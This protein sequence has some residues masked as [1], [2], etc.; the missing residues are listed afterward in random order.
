[1][2][3]IAL[4]LIIFIT[5]FN[6]YS[7]ADFHDHEILNEKEALEIFN[8]ANFVNEFTKI[9][10]KQGYDFKNDIC[11]KNFYTINHSNLL[12]QIFELYKDEKNKTYYLKLYKEQLKKFEEYLPLFIKHESALRAEYKRRSNSAILAKQGVVNPLPQSACTNMDIE[13]G[14]LSGWSTNFSNVGP[15]FS[16]FWTPAGANSAFA[17]TPGPDAAVP[18]INQVYSGSFSACI[19]VLG[20]GNG[21]DWRELQQ[22][23]LVTNANKDFV[24]Y[25]AVITDG[26]AHAC[27][28]NPFFEVN[29]FDASNNVI[30][31][32]HVSLIGSASGGGACSQFTGWNTAGWYDFL[33]W[34]PVIVP[35]GAYIG[36]NVTVKF[37]VQRCTAYGHGARAYIEASC[38]PVDLTV[39]GNLICPGKTVSLV[40]PNT[41]GY[42][43]NWSGPGGFSAS[44]N[45]VS[46]SLSGAYTVTMSLISNPTCKMVM[47]TIL[48]SVPSP[49]AN[50]NYTVTP[51]A[52]TNS[53]PVISSS[54]PAAGDPISNYIWVWGDASSNG[55]GISTNHTYASVG[56]KTVELKI[57]STAGCRDSIQQSFSFNPG[58]VASFNLANSCLGTVSSFTSTSTSATGIAFQDWN[59]GDGSTNGSGVNPS[60]SYSLTGTY[61]VTLVVTAVGGCTATVTQTVAVYPKP[62]VTFTANPVC[63]NSATSFTNSSTITAPG[64]INAWA[65]D[66]DND[67]TTDNITQSPA[68]TFTPAGTYNIELK[69][70][71]SN[72]CSDS[73]VV[74]IIINANPI[75]TFT[76][77]AAC[78]NAN[79][80]LNNTSTIPLPNTINLY[81]WAFGAGSTPVNSSNQNPPSLTYNTSG[82]KTITLTL[83]ANNSCTAT[84]TNT[85]TINPFPVA[86]FSTTSV[87]Q[88]TATAFTDM[89]TISSGTI[90]TWAWDY[91]NDG[92]SD[93]ATQNPTF[94]YPLSGSY[95]AAL[96]VS[97]TAGCTNTFTAPVTVWGHTIPDFSPNNV[98]FGTATT[99]SNNTNTTTNANVGTTP[100]YSW[101][102]ADGSGVQVLAGSPAH[103]YTLGGNVNATYNVT[104]TATSSHNCI[105]N[106][107]KAVNVYA[108]PTASFTS[109]S[110]CLGSPSHMADATNGNGNTVNN[111]IWDFLSNG[112]IDASGVSNPNFTFPAYGNNAVTYTAS[113]TPVAGLTCQN[114]TSTIT[115]WINPNPIPD[116]T[117]VNKCINAQP[118]TFDA[119]NST[120]AVG[121]NTAYT[122]AF[123][124]GATSP[125]TITPTHTF[126]TAGLYNTTLTVTSNKGCQTSVTKQVE[127]YQKPL[128]SI[129][130]SSACFKSAMTFT[131]GSLA[132]S[133]TVNSWSWDLNNT[134]ASYEGFGEFPNFNFPVAGSQTVHLVA[135][136]THGCTDTFTTQVY[137]DYLP[138]P[139]FTVD[140]PSGCPLHCVTFTDNTPALTA[141]GI[142]N[143]WHW[144]FGDGQT[145]TVNSP[146]VQSHCYDNTSNSQSALYDVKLIVTSDK[147]CKDSLNKQ[148]FITVYPTPIAQYTVD[149]NPGS[150]VTPTEHF[151][152]QSVDY[153]KWWW[154]F[155]DG[156]ISDSTHLNPY[157]TYLSLDASDYYSYLIVA[158]QYGCKDTANVKLEIG[159][160]F[161]FYIPNAFTPD[162]GDGIND[163]F[164]GMGVGIDKFEMWIFDR[165]GVSIF[166]SD[167]IYK[168][169]NGKVQGTEALVQ[170]DVYTWKVKI[171]DVLGKGHNY[172]GHVTVLR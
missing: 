112:T 149:P 58:P 73:L 93:N 88:S 24:F 95:T 103:T 132:G 161:V 39:N 118:N 154:C 11:L 7:Q 166:Y 150:I 101:D 165:W 153:T 114:I 168:G 97:T 71:S 32:S 49:T 139:A 41:P 66:F 6:V 126:V 74:P 171:K 160:E 4:L 98:C 128:M 121:T 159:P 107:V 158:N 94:T 96:T 79:V 33:N 138:T 106:I 82:V 69:A 3:K 10:T 46:P 81:D 122:W 167:D 51:C 157:H 75:A 99:F 116:F 131:A 84:I 155:G 120:I 163:F 61:S 35:L 56:T 60:H 133:G 29:V 14:S 67:G 52:P 136:T 108:I 172:V 117:F 44:T 30:P 109:D 137:V 127:V 124:D 142:N 170:Q 119:S 9:T 123:G 86:N 34:T 63:L 2:K 27:P 22:T 15:S 125:S 130:A 148:A 78:V 144:V 169:W 91:T 25:T 85:V 38:N 16:N 37:R 141:P 13:T 1:M 146:T 48:V 151:I 50:F 76:P 55:S 57:V 104:L 26:G 83:T 113:T 77:I 162:N 105:D 147:G 64:T 87:C 68:N 140:K 152:N 23:F 156:P 54:S 143:S 115:V 90:N 102:F 21:I 62:T 89:S 59:W 40:A 145:V 135:S 18:A 45:S 111:Y 134:I 110:V 36:Q 53:V 28:D 80:L 65:W 5:N 92:A 129:T 17:S 20:S 12:A 43:Y 42:N 47:D 19:D 72:G 100:T 31:C 164:T 70:T 8:Y